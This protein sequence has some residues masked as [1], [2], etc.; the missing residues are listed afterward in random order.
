MQGQEKTLEAVDIGR[1]QAAHVMQCWAA[2]GDYTPIPVKR[3][4][5]CWIITPDGRRIFDLRSAHESSNIGFN[6]PRV[7]T[8]MREQ[9]EKIVYVT[10]DFATEPTA[11]LAARLASLS[12]GGP[13]KKI[14]FS[15]SGAAAVEAAVKGARLAQYNRLFHGNGL[16]ADAPRQYPLPFKIISRY[17][18]WHGATAG[19][20][21]VSGDPRRWFQEPFTDPGVVFAPEANSDRPMF[22]GGSGEVDRHLEYLDYLIEHEGGRGRVAAMIVEPV[23]GSNGII[24]APPGYLQ[25]IRNLCD[26][27]GLFMI[28]DETMTGMGRTGRLFAVEHDGVVP[29]ILIMGKAL[30][31]YCPL[32]ATIFSESVARE[33]EAHIFGHGQSFAAHA[34]SCAAAL[35]SL[36]V[37]SE[38]GF[39]DEVTRKGIRLGKQLD[40]IAS[41]HRYIATVRGL[42]L[43]WT[44]ELRKDT[45]AGVPLRKFTQK[46]ETGVMQ[47]IS[48]YLL[49]EKN[50]YVPG[51]KFGIWIVPPL[52][53]SDD[54]IDWLTEALDDTLTM[55]DR[56]LSVAQ[57]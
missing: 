22:G 14:F 48:R 40:D 52:V 53:V 28:V 42:G 16:P 35:A 31:A 15:Q 33:F 47:R 4:E 29:D 44:I 5:G 27:W 18:S 32:A 2:Q 1:L 34:L 7:L 55:A 25:G 17:K 11:R 46:Y 21:S 10:D 13:N 20:G 23:A 49:E 26:K 24:P 30:G 36:E 41:R 19:A 37:V 3:T 45:D 38:P 54:E 51:D 9:M 57:S 56:W 43:F 12:P 6:H 39:L 8:A 50:I